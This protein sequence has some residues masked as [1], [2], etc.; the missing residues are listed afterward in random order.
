MQAI[1]RYGTE[2]RYETA[3]AISKLTRI[4]VEA[5]LEE[6]KRCHDRATAEDAP[7]AA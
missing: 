5:L 7:E 1:V 6:S 3:A 4:P 2:P